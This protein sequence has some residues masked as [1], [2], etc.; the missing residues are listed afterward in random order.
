MMA[1][2]NL[3]FGVIAERIEIINSAQL[4]AACVQWA[5]QPDKPIGEILVERGWIRAQQR[6][7]VRR[8]L[9]QELAKHGGDARAAIRAETGEKESDEAAPSNDRQ[10]NGDRSGSSFEHTIDYASQDGSPAASAAAVPPEGS[11]SAAQQGAEQAAK[12]NTN[13]LEQTI[14]SVAPEVKTKSDPF[15]QTMDSVAPE[16]KSK[17]DPFSQT[18]DSVKPDQ[19]HLHMETIDWSP[20]TRS[21]YT[22]TRL[23]GEGGLGQVWLA[24]DTLLNREVALKEVLPRRQ[25]EQEKLNRLVKE[26][27]ITGQLEHPSIIPVYE[28]GSDPNS[29]NPY[30]TMKFLRGETLSD[31]ISAYHQRRREGKAEPLE[32]RGLLNA[33]VGVC[34]A[35]AYAEARGV[36]HR[37]LKPGNIMVGDFGEVIVLDWGLAKVIGE[38]DED[39]DQRSVSVSDIAAD[40]SKTIE[41]Q[42]VGSPAFM[43]PEQADG[44]LDLIDGR[45]DVYGLGAILFAILTGQPPHK[46]TETGNSVRDTMDLLKRITSGDIPKPHDIDP[47][48]PAPLNAICAKAMAR[49]RADRYQKPSQLAD[50]VERWLADEPVSVYTEPWRERLGRW[51]RKHRSWTQAIAAAL[52]I[53]AVVSVVAFF[54]VDGAR[55]RETAALA[56]ETKAKLRAEEALESEKVALAKEKESRAEALRRFQDARRAVD[57]AL[58]GVSNVLMNYPGFLEIRT[59][60]LTEAANDYERFSQE[61]SDDPQLQAEFARALV[62]LGDVRQLLNQFDE[63]KAAYQSA[64]AVFGKLSKS[65]KD[66]L[67][68]RMDQA[69]S[70]TKVGVV[71]GALGDY[72]AAETAFGDAADIFGELTTASDDPK[73]R[74]AL[75]RNLVTRGRSLDAAGKYDEARGL[76]AS[77]VTEFDKLVSE[78]N[79]PQYVD[80]LAEAQMWLGRVL[81]KLDRADDAVGSISAAINDLDILVIGDRNHDHPE[82]FERRA[83]AKIELA[84]AL[85]NSGRETDRATA[86]RSAAADYEDLIADRPGVPHYRENLAVARANLAQVLNKLGDN[87]EAKEL[88][89]NALSTFIDLR[90]ASPLFPRYLIEEGACSTIVGDILDDLGDDETALQAFDNAI[91][92][93]EDLA[94]FDPNDHMHRRRLAMARRE[95]GRLLHKLGRHDEAKDSYMQAVA[96]FMQELQLAK[97]NPE[98]QDELATCYEQLGDLLW[99]MEMPEAA[100]P[101]YERALALRAKLAD[102]PERLFKR[103]SLL[104]HCKDPDLADWNQAAELAAQATQQSPR[105]AKYWN[106]LA[107]AQYRDGKWDEC[108]KSLS[109]ADKLRGRENSFDLLYQAMAHKRL[110]MDGPAQSAFE[111]AGEAE[112]FQENQGEFRLRELRREAAALLG[113]P[114]DDGA[115]KPPAAPAP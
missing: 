44:R 22:L 70:T 62:R 59:Q 5:G 113:L 47:K 56:A 16:E 83:Q 51:M 111:K 49:K 81:A 43:A 19:K 75:A 108:L 66:N 46:G 36:V 107:A 96:D 41:G 38:P 105:S 79:Q 106:L 64:Q 93:F 54:I 14:D 78:S 1:D 40:A 30:Y 11:A 42:V 97:D 34:N 86:F 15:E 21:R 9:Q 28:L 35:M 17:E 29:G 77:A 65:L 84:N 23:H 99:Q 57:R 55:R 82:Y 68:L 31:R 48:I 114:A 80:G 53:V 4:A 18:M 13:P 87:L 102:D 58:T 94:Q 90:S 98:A 20:E 52:L 85:R 7:L 69:A 67:D 63:A 45:T 39:I 33:F 91:V 61:K 8:T 88:A 27:Q 76:L 101:N 6:E 110:N 3:L 50:D 26:A 109:S 89:L 92:K 103:A 72:A 74:D 10:G 24:V 112:F 2:E 95:L 60:L 12:S 73:Y 32:M 115:A 25:H 104:A 100:K 71:C 37:D